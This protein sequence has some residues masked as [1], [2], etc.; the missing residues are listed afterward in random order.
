MKFLDNLEVVM[1]VI[2]IVAL[3]LLTCVVSKLV[4]VS[5]ACHVLGI[6]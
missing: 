4:T 5:I 1:M 6:I 3:V 2:L